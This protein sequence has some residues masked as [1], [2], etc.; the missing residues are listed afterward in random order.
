MV[1]IVLVLL[2]PDSFA[3]RDDFGGTGGF[4]CWLRLCRLVGQDGILRPIG[5][6]PPTLEQTSS[7]AP[8]AHCREPRIIDILLAEDREVGTIAFRRG[9]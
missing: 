7:G 4:A 8:M 1:K 3:R 9:I 2:H 5:N 6:R